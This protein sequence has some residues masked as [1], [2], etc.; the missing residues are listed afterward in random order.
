M[1]RTHV[2]SEVR[3]MN[4]DVVVDVGSIGDTTNKT[5]FVFEYDEAVIGNSVMIQKVGPNIVAI[6]EL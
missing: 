4:E 2:D 5:L 1:H 6:G 3:V